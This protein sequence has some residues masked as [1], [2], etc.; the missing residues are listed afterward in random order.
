[1][2]GRDRDQAGIL[3]EL[4]TDLA[5]DVEDPTRFDELR[6]KIWYVAHVTST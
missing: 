6:N 1:V 5:I 3:V 4:T 2:F